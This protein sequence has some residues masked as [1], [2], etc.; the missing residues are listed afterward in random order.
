MHFAFRASLFRSA[1]K[2]IFAQ[3]FWVEINIIDIVLSWFMNGRHEKTHETKPYINR[4]GNPRAFRWSD[5]KRTLFN[6]R[7]NYSFCAADTIG[8]IITKS[9]R[10]PSA[11]VP[12][13]KAFSHLWFKILIYTAR[14]E[15]ISICWCH[16]S[17]FL[18]KKF[19]DYGAGNLV[20]HRSSSW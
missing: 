20:K 6:T 16:E 2:T 8:G 17:C 10:S 13:S 18:V 11:N 1:P 3:R 5:E 7:V 9:F 4:Q 15:K 19:K 12:S 14:A